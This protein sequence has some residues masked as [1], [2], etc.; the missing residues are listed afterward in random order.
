MK[1]LLSKIVSVLLLASS[2]AQARPN[3]H[4]VGWFNM[5]V[6]GCGEFLLGNYSYGTLQAGLEVG[7]FYWG[8]SS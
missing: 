7:T 6:L 8:R 1:K 4:T 2:T 5:F 3:Y